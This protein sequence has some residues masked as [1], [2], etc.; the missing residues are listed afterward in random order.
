MWCPD[1]HTAFD[2]TTGRIDLGRVHNP[3]YYEFKVRT[4]LAGREHADIPCGGIPEFMEL[5]VVTDNTYLFG[6]H[7][8]VIHVDVIVIPQYTIYEMLDT[9]R[10]RMN[11]L[12]NFI[13]EQEFK[14][15]LQCL[16]KTREKHRDV[17][18]ILRMFVDTCGDYLRQFVNEPTEAK[19]LEVI[20][21]C[22]KIKTYANDTLLHLA[23]RYNSNIRLLPE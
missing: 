5:R 1:C 14:R 9:R 22:A 15:Y 10:A 7:R 12:R 21:A 11:Y 8:L 4:G 16:E 2:W 3:H 6:I 18:H 23:K 20:D 17:V 13:T 19:K